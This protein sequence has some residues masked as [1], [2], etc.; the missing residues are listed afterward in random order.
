MVC[1]CFLFALFKSIVHPLHEMYLLKYWRLKIIKRHSGFC[2]KVVLESLSQNTEAACTPLYHNLVHFKFFFFFNKVSTDLNCVLGYFYLKLQIIVSNH[3][4]VK[5]WS[6]CTYWYC[7]WF[8]LVNS[9]SFIVTR[10][11]FYNRKQWLPSDQC[12]FFSFIPFYI[13][14]NEELS[15]QN[16]PWWLDLDLTW[17]T[18]HHPTLT[19]TLTK[20]M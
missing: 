10:V 12:I 7:L 15:S 14:D 20:K 16:D 3:Y 1:W 2:P 6:C 5:P 11:I 8:P 17:N 18:A 4:G 19:T 13:K 9:Y